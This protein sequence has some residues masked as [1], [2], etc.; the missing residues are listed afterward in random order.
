MKETEFEFS[1]RWWWIVIAI[2]ALI[3]TGFIG[4]VWDINVTQP[5]NRQ[6][7]DNNAARQIAVNQHFHQLLADIQTARVQL[8]TDENALVQF[9]QTHATGK[10]SYQDSQELN[11]LENNVAQD[12]LTLQAD[13]NQY[14]TDMNNP[15]WKGADASLPRFVQP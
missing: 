14:N 13:C 1:I 2:V 15:D 9:E 3:L 5:M 4:W 12:H 11:Q 6:T 7:I 10:M 8:T